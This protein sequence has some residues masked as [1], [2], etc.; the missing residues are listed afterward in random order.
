M[1]KLHFVA[2]AVIGLASALPA[3]AQFQKPEDAIKYRQSAMTL[4]GAHF[5][6]IAAMAQGKIPFDAKTAAENAALVDTLVHLPFAAF[7]EGTER[8]APTQAKPEIWKEP[9]KFKSAA[10][11]LQE[12][13]GKLNVAAK[14]G[15]LD[16]IKGAVGGVGKAC[17]ACHDDFRSKEFTS[18]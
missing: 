1:K 7:G 13:V 6:R 14:T 12:E 10:E 16:A 4:I 8:G 11:K 3:A 2:A 15:S 9:A 17:K 18:N 5:G